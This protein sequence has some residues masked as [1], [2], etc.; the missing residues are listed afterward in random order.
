MSFWLTC[1]Q[2]NGRKWCC[3]TSGWGHKKQ[4]SSALWAE[5]SPRSRD[6]P[7]KHSDG[8]EASKLWRSPNSP[9]W[10]H[11]MTVRSGR[12]PASHQLLSPRPAPAIIQLQ[13]AR[14]IQNHPNKSSFPVPQKLWDNKILAVLS[15]AS[16]VLVDFLKD[17]SRLSRKKKKI[18]ICA[19][20]LHGVNPPTMANLQLPLWWLLSWEEMPTAGSAN[21]MSWLQCIELYPAPKT[22]PLQSQMES[23]DVF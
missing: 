17:N 3:L 15:T 6:P 5:H 22:D 2:Q 1:N 11:C 7:C 12:F 10:R 18:Q 23:L 4:F 19:Y 13:N 14:E 16:D 21:R 9:T 20:Y 8:S